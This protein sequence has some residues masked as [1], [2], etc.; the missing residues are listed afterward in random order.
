MLMLFQPYCPLLSV[1]KIEIC[2]IKFTQFSS[3]FKVADKYNLMRAMVSIP[4]GLLST[5]TVVKS[6]VW[7]SILI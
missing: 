3:N 7:T 4:N 2:Q 6:A 5:S 1:V